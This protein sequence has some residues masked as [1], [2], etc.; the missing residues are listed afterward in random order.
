MAIELSAPVSTNTFDKVWVQSITVSGSPTGK[1]VAMVQMKPFD[2]THTL[3]RVISMTIPD[4]FGLAG[5]DPVFAGIV[6][7][8]LGE[9]ERQ[10]KLRNLI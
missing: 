5:T 2:G 9:V 4:V 10:A 6:S 3:D 8:L 7:S 1:T